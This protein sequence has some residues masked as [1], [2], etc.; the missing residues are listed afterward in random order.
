M[1]E[2]LASSSE[3]MQNVYTPLPLKLHLIFCIIATVIYLIQFSRKGSA[4]YLVI[5]LAVDL[6]FVTQICTKTI[7]MNCLFGAEIVLLILAAVLS[8]RFN[9]KQKAASAKQK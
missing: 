2:I 8:F 1:T 6:T 7:V 5:M 9:K 3:A 4:H